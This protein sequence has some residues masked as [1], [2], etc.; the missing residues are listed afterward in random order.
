MNFEQTY[1]RKP[2]L[3]VIT[4]GELKRYTHSER[5]LQL[6]SN[7]SSSWFTK[8]DVG[9]ANNFD[10][11]EIQMDAH[12]TTDALLRLPRH[13]KYIKFEALVCVKFLNFKFDAPRVFL[14]L[15][16]SQRVSRAVRQ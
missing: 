6:Y 9:E 5:R 11:T 3:A 16:S 2:S 14:R 10:V 8:T 12:T 13:A 15:I 7:P 1:G 4:V